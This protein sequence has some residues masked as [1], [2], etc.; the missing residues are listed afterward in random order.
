MVPAS[1]IRIGP[2]DMYV[3]QVIAPAYLSSLRVMR[4]HDIQTCAVPAQ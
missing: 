3:Y 1:F 2:N 4:M